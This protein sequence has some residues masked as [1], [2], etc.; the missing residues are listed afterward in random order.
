MSL[1]SEDGRDEL[2]YFAAIDHENS[3]Y[4]TAKQ[5]L[6]QLLKAE[7]EHHEKNLQ[8]IR[9]TYDQA[10]SSSEERK[11]TM[12]TKRKATKMTKQEIWN[13]VKA[14]SLTDPASGI[15]YVKH[16]KKTPSTHTRI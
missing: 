15:Q 4:I 13:K 3:R 11:A 6:E 10:Q 7:K 5:T 9:H 12:M 1:S 2:A 14:W 16:N 8:F